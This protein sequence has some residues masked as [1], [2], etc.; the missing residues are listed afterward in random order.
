MP[1]TSRLLSQL[2]G[3]PADGRAGRRSGGVTADLFPKGSTA[4]DIDRG[5]H[6]DLNLN[7]PQSDSASYAVDRQGPRSFRTVTHHRL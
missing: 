4:G 6:L 2:P 7:G 5:G 3:T 1:G